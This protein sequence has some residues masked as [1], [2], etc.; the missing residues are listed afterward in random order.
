MNVNDAVMVNRAFVALT[1]AS[2]RMAR[3]IKVIWFKTHLRP[4]KQ[5]QEIGC[6]WKELGEIGYRAKR[7]LENRLRF[8]EKKVLDT[9]GTRC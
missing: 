3:V 5:A 4:Q 7:M 1:E 2:P 9:V 8:I 6:H